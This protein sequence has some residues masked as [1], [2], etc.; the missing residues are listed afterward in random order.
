MSESIPA[1][2]IRV[3]SRCGVAMVVVTGLMTVVLAVG[4]DKARYIGGNLRDFP[5][6][7]LIGAGGELRK[8]EG[9]IDTKSD[10]QLAFDAGRSGSLAIP[11][12]AVSS[13]AYGLEPHGAADSRGWI[14]AYPWDPSDQFTREPHYLLTLVYRGNAD[15]VHVVVFELGQDIV[16]PTLERLEARTGKRIHFDHV[17]ACL[18]YKTADECNLGTPDEL[19]GL[20]KVFVDTS[21][22]RDLIVSE[23]EKQPLGLQLLPQAEGAEVIL[24]FRTG[25]SHLRPVHAGRGEV[26]I[27]RDG[28]LRAVIVFANRLTGALFGRDKPATTFGRTFVEAYQ[29]ANGVERGLK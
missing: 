19:K 7:G 9:P 25:R 12:S 29:Q 13:V 2:P 6:H 8:V 5:K 16:R 22:D 17:T 10:S 1:K 20:K 21:S 27:A 24:K 28:R 26:Y 23:I 4:K 3:R 18:E 11:Y 14:N 15:A